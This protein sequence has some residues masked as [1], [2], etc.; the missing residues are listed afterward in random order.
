MD[1]LM[2]EIINYGQMTNK[3][4]CYLPESCIH[5]EDHEQQ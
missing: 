1:P 2:N 4:R 5:E 3:A